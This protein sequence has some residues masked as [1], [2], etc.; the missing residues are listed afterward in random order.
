MHPATVR[1]RGGVLRL[2]TPLIVLLGLALTALAWTP[3]SYGVVLRQLGAPEAGL[4]WGEPQEIRSDEYVVW[5]PLVQATTRNS[6]ARH[7]ATSPY[8]EDLRNFN[9]LPLWDWALPLKPAMW[10][11]YGP[12]DPARAFA[13]SWALP[14][15]AFLL[16]WER[17]FRRLGVDGTAAIAA[18]GTLWMTGYVQTWWTTTGPLLAAWP[19][20]VLA[21]LAP[22]PARLRVPL[23]AWTTAVCLLS[24]FYPPLLLTLALVGG[25]ALTLANADRRRWIVTAG[26]VAVGV[27]MVT[28]YLWDVIPTMADTVYPG[29]RVS[30]GGGV[31][32]LQALDLVLP[33]LSAWLGESR[34]AGTNVCEATTAGTLVPLLVALAVDRGVLAT[35]WQDAR[36]RR[37]TAL[38]I[39]LLA[40]CMAWMLLP[41]PS[42]LGAGLGWH[43]VP[44][45][46][47]V[48]PAGVVLLLLALR[49]P[50]RLP[51]GLLV[52]LAWAWNLVHW[53]AFNPVQDARPIFEPPETAALTTLRTSADQDPRGWLVVPGFGGAVLNGLG[54]K[55][56]S[57]ALV[58]P[59]VDWFAPHFPEL[60]AGELRRIFNR[61]SHVQ[62]SAVDAPEV[63]RQDVVRVPLAL[64]GP[65]L[66]PLGVRTDPDLA[67][68]FPVG[69]WIDRITP[70][71]TTVITGWGLIDGT[72]DGRGLVIRTS[73]PIR[74][75]RAEPMLR[76]DVV[77]ATGDSGLGASGFRLELDLVGSPEGPLCIVTDDPDRGRHLVQQLGRT[78]PC[79]ELRR[80]QP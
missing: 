75:A 50:T 43:K 9:A 47:M 55:S 41:L 25:A 14:L 59:Q 34:L 11:F 3:S 12:L 6:G 71:E 40:A 18:S 2:W 30:S 65:A 67:T 33:G 1:Y 15:V 24:H 35:R 78:D 69:G 44:P 17:L 45:V 46:R 68:R 36:W 22:W 10:G 72:Q 53:A 20:V 31:P 76:P 7:N 66:K 49:V 52:T 58:T 21:A 5:T 56:V 62:L 42:W 37:D 39:G 64:F 57:H 28:A 61:Y 19:W 74:S 26:G 79:R 73:W 8:G 63:I 38:L 16:G 80:T 60:G 77:R 23:V 54:F 13:W 48:V 4:I 32:V 70:G 51:L 27:A 29:Q